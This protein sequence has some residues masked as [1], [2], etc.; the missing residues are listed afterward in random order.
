MARKMYKK[1]CSKT[2]ET[3]EKLLKELSMEPTKTAKSQLPCV[4]LTCINLAGY[5][6]AAALIFG[7]NEVRFMSLLKLKRNEVKTYLN[8]YRNAR[9]YSTKK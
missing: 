8:T 7:L 6:Q 5:L 3:I 9:C 1:L 2:G 4:G